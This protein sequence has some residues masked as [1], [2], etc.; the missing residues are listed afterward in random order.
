V[1]ALAAAIEERDSYTHEHSDEVVHLARGVAMIL[2]L[3]TAKVERIA[4]AALLHDVG[5]LGVPHEILHK[6]GPLTEEEWAVMAEHP[7]A[8]ERIL[9]RL[10]ELAPIAPIVRHEHEHWDGSGYPDR[11]RGHNIPIGSRI[12]LACDAYEAMTTPRP[13]RPAMSREEAIDQL[14]AGSGTT[15]DPDVVDALLDLLGVDRPAVPDRALGVRLA[16][17]VP[18]LEGRRRR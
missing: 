3:A 1:Q 7:V 15:Y 5:K 6:R 12:I 9:L 16:A 14:R 11:L 18:K 2:G 13:Y 4:H 10:P 8:G 17:P